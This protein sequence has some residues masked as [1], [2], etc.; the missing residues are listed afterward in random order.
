MNDILFR[1]GTNLCH[2]C[3]EWQGHEAFYKQQ[4]RRGVTLRTQ[5]KMLTCN[6]NI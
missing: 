5:I 2:S 6:F 1:E 3:H 4:N